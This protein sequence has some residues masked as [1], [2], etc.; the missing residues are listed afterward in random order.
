MWGWFLSNSVWVL[1]SAA[2]VVLLLLFF[3]KRLRHGIARMVPERWQDKAFG[4]I[5]TIFW[6]VEGIAVVVMVLAFV[7]VLLFREG[8]PTVVTTEAVRGW[9][10]GHGITIIIILI[11]GLALWTA[12]QRFLPPLVNRV[13]ARPTRRENRE[14]LKK[15]ADTLQ[16]VFLG[17]GRIIIILLVILMVLS[18]LGIPVGPILAGFGVV[19]VAVGFGAQYMVRDL[20]AGV[21]IL[22]ENQYRMGDM[23]KVA[24]VGGIVEEINLRKTVLRDMDGAVHHVPNGEIRV[25]SNYSRQFARVNL[26]VSV[27]YG[28]DLDFAMS[29]INRVCQELAAEEKW[30]KVIKTVPQALRVE[31]LGESGVEIKVVGNVQPLEQWNV[32][33][34]LRLRL[35]KAFEAEGIVIPIS[36]PNV[37]SGNKPGE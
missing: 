24:G 35:M 32:T 6:V 25:A 26:N 16:G 1:I 19:G 21:F 5:T 13:M 9:F 22:M 3:G 37:Y 31:N 17:L 30:G 2:A 12:L 11:V 20:I 10:L 4:K 8:V 27:A 28:T 15:R 34:E 23:V 33:G 7:A 29:V 36:Y 18:E 14:G